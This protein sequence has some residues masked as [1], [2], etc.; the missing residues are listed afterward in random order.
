MNELKKFLRLELKHIND[1]LAR[2]GDS[3]DNI[4]Q[5]ILRTRKKAIEEYLG[6]RPKR[7]NP[8]GN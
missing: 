3:D 8:C 5:W 4:V 2:R 6:I 1:T 7:R